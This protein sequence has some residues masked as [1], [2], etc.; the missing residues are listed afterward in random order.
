MFLEKIMEKS[1][2]PVSSSENDCIADDAVD[3]AEETDTPPS[4]VSTGG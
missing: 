1:L 3:E 4:S 2:T